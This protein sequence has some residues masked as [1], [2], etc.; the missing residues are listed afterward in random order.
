MQL[1]VTQENLSRALGAV[2][3][4][5]SSRN[6]LPILSNVLLK[7]VDGRLHVSATNL[8]IGI[9]QFTGAKITEDGAITVPAR[10]MN[11]FV[12]SL[13]QGTITLETEGQKLH[14]RTEKYV[15]TINGVSA[16]EFPVLPALEGGK[17]WEC[18]AQELKKALSRVIFAASSDE[19][20]PVLTGVYLF[21]DGASVTLAATDSYRLAEKK[22]K[23][24]NQPLSMLVPATAF[25]DVARIIGDTEGDLIVQYD[26]QQLRFL[27]PSGEVV[28]RQLEGSYPE[29]QKLIPTEF[30]NRAHVMK[31]DFLNITKV[32][33]LFA[34]ES[35]GSVTL[36][37]DP[38]KQQV[39]IRAIASQLGDNTA[40]A[41][42]KIDG[43]GGK[44]TL[45]SRYILDALAAFSGKEVV[46]SFNDKLG[47]CV[48]TSD[49]DEGYKHVIM[50][51]RS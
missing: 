22:L 48:L 10:L 42:A 20:R 27:L 39:S 51:L 29:Y 15:S 40:E 32:S 18:D 26:D 2:S 5:A 1:Q 7:T 50:P 9:T 28:S 31:E 33:S 45:N 4:V 43:D 8:D 49:E 16:E 23:K 21:D 6:A 41:P 46:F 14:I 24:A 11:D 47:A 19:T 37:I 3:K 44:V 36:E 30:K 12:S 17:Q 25:Q 38:L 35:A 13:P 34:R